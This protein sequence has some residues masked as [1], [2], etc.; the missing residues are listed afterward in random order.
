MSQNDSLQFDYSSIFTISSSNQCYLPVSIFY[1]F[2]TYLAYLAV[3][4]SCLSHSDMWLSLH[5]ILCSVIKMKKCS[6]AHA[7]PRTK[8]QTQSRECT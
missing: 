7:Q 8:T 1:L 3:S 5:F 4:E 2:M 6:H